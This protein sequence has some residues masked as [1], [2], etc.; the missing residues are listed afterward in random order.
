MNNFDRYSRQTILP[1]IGEAGQLALSEARIL[2]VGAGGLGCPAL[3]YLAAAGV[4]HIGIIDDDRV[5]DSNLQRQVL[6]T[7]D[8][9]GM[10]KAVAARA[11][12]IARNPDISVTAYEERLSADNCERLFS[13]HDIII[14]GTDNFD[15]KFLI[16]D[17]A[18]KFNKP[19]VYAAILGFDGQVSVFTTDEQSPCFRCL[20]PHT[21]RNHVANCAEAGVIGS[22][23]GMM[24]TVQALEVIKLI[25]N[26]DDLPSIAGN[27]WTIDTKSFTAN[28][29]TLPRDPDCTV[30]SHPKE[31][32]SLMNP[33]SSTF[34][35]SSNEIDLDQMQDRLKANP[36][37]IL[38]DVREQ[39]EWDAGHVDGAQLLPLSAL[40]NG[41]QADFAKD[42]EVIIYCKAGRRSLSALQILQ[43][44]GFENLV[45]VAPGYD[46]WALKNG[47][48]G[49]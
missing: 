19:W 9:I 13:A 16:N 43:A 22:V 45:S 20:F 28:T 46:G 40:S 48:A 26:N 8:Q 37:A 1:E 17:A 2:C 21:P 39:N 34:C 35:S 6:Y 33:T 4:G 27:L 42:A 25:V 31:S 47:T 12:L 41:A 10:N 29:I 3:L 36:D 15:S 44:Q 30:C 38:L 14:D 5:E 24:G 18:V 7:H 11:H 32:I 49:Q 23:A